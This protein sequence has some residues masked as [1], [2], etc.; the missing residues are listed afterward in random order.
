MVTIFA[1]AAAVLY[2]GADFLGGTASRR[3]ETLAVL[4]VSAPFGALVML[5]AALASGDPLRLG[6]LG[7]AVAAGV[8]GGCGLIV[9]YR[10]LAIG[11]MSVVAPV[12]ALVSTLLPVGVAVAWGERQKPGVYLGA[13]VCLAAIVLVSM[14]RRAGGRP[15][16]RRGTL[17]ALINGTGAGISFGLFFLFLRNAGESSGVFW[18]VTTARVAG[19]A[20]ILAAA[21][22]KGARLEWR[23]TSP[24]VLAAA[25]L[26]GVID[27]SA[28]VCYLLAT[29]AGLFG[30]AV[31]LTSLYPGITVLLARF[32]L[33]ERMQTVQRLGLALA[34]AGVALVTV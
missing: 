14:E 9:F 33:G 22:W 20:I 5:A 21:F 1:L 24:R 6:G 32:V 16:D 23:T 26:S 27:A 8:A 29:Q 4:T 31:I 30:V 12:S 3:A 17:R 18:P 2:G 13:L 7:W 10:G 19:M 34:A 11:P 25:I 15:R 28:N